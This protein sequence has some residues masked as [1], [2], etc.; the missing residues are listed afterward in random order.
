MLGMAHGR[1]MTA[2]GVVIREEREIKKGKEEGEGQ[3]GRKGISPRFVLCWRSKVMTSPTVAREA[4]R[5]KTKGGREGWQSGVHVPQ[6][7]VNMP[8]AGNSIRLCPEAKR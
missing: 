4:V 7:P 8:S 5:E 6:N 2:A 1:C 3:K